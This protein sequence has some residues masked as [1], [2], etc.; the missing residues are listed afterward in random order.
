MEMDDSALRHIMDMQTQM[1]QNLTRLQ[2]QQSRTELQEQNQA[3][4]ATIQDPAALLT[5]NPSEIQ[6]LT[7]QGNHIQT[8]LPPGIQSPVAPPV[9]TQPL[10]VS[11]PTQYGTVA[12]LP[13][14]GGRSQGAANPQSTFSARGF[15]SGSLAEIRD[16]DATRH[17]REATSEFFSQQTRGIQ[18]QAVNVV[19]G[20]VS[21]ATA[22][23]SMLIP[24][25]L[26]SLVVGGAAAVGVGT[27]ASAIGK[28]A[29]DS[30][31]YQELLQR[32]DY[33]F[34]NAFESTD[35]LGGIGMGLEQRQEVSGFLRDLA[36]EKF[37]E[38]TDMSKILEG[39]SQNSLLKS[40][41][42]VK[43]FKEKF[44]SI[45]DAVKEIAVTM[46][47]T[48]D[49]A[50]AFMG[51]MERRG[52]STKDMPFIAAQT[53][54]T[55]SMAGISTQEAAQAV[56][57]TSDSIVQGTN[58]DA[59][60]IASSTTQNIAFAQQIQDKAKEEGNDPLYHYIKNIGGAK[61]A[62]P[63]YEQVAR[64][65]IQSDEG[66]NML[67]GMFGSAFEQTKDGGFRINEAEMD[68]LMNS[69]MSNQDLEQRSRAFTS[70]LSA[71]QLARL[72]G[73]AAE[74]FSTSA[75]SYDMSRFLKRNIEVIRD[76]AP[77]QNISDTTALV[78]GLGITQNYSEAEFIGAQIEANSDETKRDMLQS[79]ALK[80]EMDSNAIANN[81]GLITRMKYWGERNI[82][83]PIGDVGQGISDTLGTGMQDYQKWLTGV[84]DRSM[85]GGAP[86]PAFTDK[87]I[88]DT[89]DDLKKMDVATE[90]VAGD[91]RERRDRALER[92]DLIDYAKYDIRQADIEHGQVDHKRLDQIQGEDVSTFSGAQLN[93]Y[94]D[95]IRS[96]TMSAAEVADLSQRKDDMG[97]IEQARANVAIYAAQGDYEGITGKLEY[98]AARAGIGIAAGVQSLWN[99]TLGKT[100]EGSKEEADFNWSGT[101][102]S[103]RS[104]EKSRKDL[105]GQRDS[106]SGEVMSLFSSGDL[107]D[108]DKSELKKLEK[109]IEKGDKDSVNAITDNGEASRLASRYSELQQTEQQFST[110]MESYTTASRQTKAIAT[111]GSQLGDLLKTAGVYSESEIDDLLGG[112]IKRGDDTAKDLKK[113]KMTTQ[114]MK[115]ASKTTVKEM[116]AFF[117]NMLDTDA[118]KLAGFL[119]K[120]DPKAKEAI[121]DDAGEVNTEELQKYVM[122]ELRD[123]HVT[124]PDKAKKKGKSS[125]EDAKQVARDHEEAMG[126]YLS[127]LQNETG[128]LRD[129]AEGR[130]VRSNT[131]TLQESRGS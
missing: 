71:D 62:G 2:E 44:T 4:T 10:A 25:I 15:I 123:Q 124:D 92:G 68:K 115:E 74:M 22:A 129:A 66:T 81:P 7:L 13:Y 118:E 37:L 43:S 38:D 42:D 91:V 110:G 24:G 73:S 1:L 116:D 60:T 79:R 50:T 65:F 28:G 48:L 67:I 96:D 9:T 113:G 93:T 14:V 23:G 51:E 102:L 107:N 114:E 94:M 8:P 84:D 35:E 36:P 104:L 100:L 19:G 130:P 31:D 69:D 103:K 111:S 46:N 72:E 63:A 32:E 11:D 5:S 16:F 47:S 52:I 105:M 90:A 80:E 30:L 126:Y 45:V 6:R 64:G 108:L 131:S 127:S 86:L 75:D 21:G 87:G 128:M 97:L 18:E 88:E 70:T 58:I 61:A 57:Q 3:N 119:A 27:V 49:E 117:A 56:M 106:L 29:S 89:F 99:N 12:A 26:P 83:N 122:T 125:A 20:A 41:S 82:W 98:G 17:S 76:A 85:V 95:R 33:K 120:R 78:E 112:M 54:V 101:D 40:V 53:K 109:A 59:T 55:A 34:I 121:F 39:A 77:G